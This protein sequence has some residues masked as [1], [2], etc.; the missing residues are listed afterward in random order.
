MASELN[1]KGTPTHVERINP[2]L[3]VEDIAASMAYY[4]HVLGFKRYVE[5]PTIG[6][7]ARDGHQIHLIKNLRDDPPVQ[8]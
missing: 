3:N 1:G 8:L 2:C 6:I 4:I 7:I 5:T